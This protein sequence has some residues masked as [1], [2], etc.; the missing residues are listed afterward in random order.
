MPKVKVFP[1]ALV[2]EFMRAHRLSWCSQQL[3][4]WRIYSIFVFIHGNCKRN[5]HDIKSDWT[6]R[7][8]EYDLLRVNSIERNVKLHLARFRWIEKRIRHSVS[9]CSS[10]TI[11]FDW[12]RDRTW[13]RLN[14]K[15]SHQLWNFKCIHL[16]ER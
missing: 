14:M 16:S 15:I 7:V 10:F 6:I 1:L 8:N 4:L 9:K 11:W 2:T 3:S 13:K 5:T 12:N